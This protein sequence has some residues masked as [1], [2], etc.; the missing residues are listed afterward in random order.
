MRNNY[1]QKITKLI[2]IISSFSKYGK[3]KLMVKK[4]KCLKLTKYEQTNFYI[5]KLSSYCHHWMIMMMMMIQ[6]KICY[7]N[8]NTKNLIP[9]F[10]KF[11][12]IWQC[13][14]LLLSLLQMN[15][16]KITN[17]CCCLVIFYV[18]RIFFFFI[19]CLCDDIW[20]Q[21]ILCLCW[22]WWWWWI[23]LCL[24]TNFSSSSSSSST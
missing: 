6:K 24:L 15:P 10:W 19:V 5:K 17:Y 1:N 7:V 22:W 4:K 9:E 3:T 12:S 21:Q 16:Q 8:I 2:I 23:I 14:L 11:I 13:L 18:Y 20:I